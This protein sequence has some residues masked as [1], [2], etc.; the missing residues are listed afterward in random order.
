MLQ[1]LPQIALRRRGHP[2]AREAL[3]RQQIQQMLRVARV[4]LLPPHGARPNF[5]RI[6]HPQLVTELGHH[7]LEPLRVARGLDPDQRG[8]GRT[9][10]KRLRFPAFVFQPARHHLA[11]LRTQDRN[12]LVAR[13]QITSDNRHVGSF[14]GSL[15]LGQPKITGPKEPTPLWNQGRSGW[16]RTATASN[17]YSDLRFR[18]TRLSKGFRT[19]GSRQLLTMARA[20]SG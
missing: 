1:Q 5:R 20:A 11:G 2:N 7:A 16:E 4:G 3:V 17:G 14:P 15:G 10:V 8:L 19:I 6:P 12:Y 13:M 18:L 9:R